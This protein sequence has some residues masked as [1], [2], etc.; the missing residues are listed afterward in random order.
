MVRPAPRVET[1][2]ALGSRAVAWDALVDAAPLPTPFLRSWWLDAVQDG[3]G[4]YL[5]VLDDEQ[6]I[7]GL[8]LQCRRICGVPVLRFC[9]AGTL[10]PDHLDVLAAP[11]RQDEVLG[12]LRGWCA[13]PGARVLDLS[14]AVQD[15]MASRLLP[16]A[17]VEVIAAAPYEPLLAGFADYLAARPGK[18]RR[19]ARRTAQRMSDTAV[20]TRRVSTA[21][22]LDDALAAFVALHRVRGDRAELLA[23]MPRLTAALRAGH[24]V[25]E[26]IV[27]V[28]ERRGRIVAVSLALSA[29]GRLC[30][31]QNARHL[32]G[33]LGSAGTFLHLQVIERACADGLAELDLLRG[34]EAYK[35][36]LAGHQRELVRIRAAHG[37]A[38]R[39]VLAGMLAA[40]RARRLLNAQHY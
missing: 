23:E 30:L 18:F 27:D 13:R 24:A 21:A 9:G 26:V 38:G 39:L 22:D 2:R 10:C 8:A 34:T 3:T 29:G 19:E 12:A 17:S 40:R 32:D 36:Y 6:L 4:R 5:L 11:G 16:G 33:E 35:R 7:G 1:V 28:L 20:T 31:Y 14:G 25:G 37:R 15:A